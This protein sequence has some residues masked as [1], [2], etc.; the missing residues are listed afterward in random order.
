[1]SK[2]LQVGTQNDKNYVSGSKKNFER[3]CHLLYH[4]VEAD[5]KIKLG[6][7]LLPI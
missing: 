7:V 4:F 1:V 2:E 3:R 6:V 5:S